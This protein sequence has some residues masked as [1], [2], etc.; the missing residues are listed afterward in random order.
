MLVFIPIA[1]GGTVE[2]QTTTPTEIHLDGVEILRTYGPST[3]LLSDIPAGK[4]VFMVYRGGD[5]EP[6]EIEVP[7]TGMARIRVGETLLETDQIARPTDGPAPIVSLRSADGREFIVIIDGHRL[8]TLS[9][10][11]PMLLDGIPLGEHTIELR[12]PDLLVIWLSGSLTLQPGDDLKL[13]VS[14]GRMLEVFGRP[15]AWQPGS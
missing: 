9:P 6:I 1:L 14:E 15:G 2:V 4:Q 10:E 12:S 13:Q 7:D 5:G 8:G 3:A 11:S